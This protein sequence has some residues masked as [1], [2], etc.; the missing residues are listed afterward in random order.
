MSSHSSSSLGALSHRGAGLASSAARRGGLVVAPPPSLRPSAPLPSF[1]ACEGVEVPLPTGLLLGWNAAMA[2]FH[3]VLAGTTLA[4]G[5]VGLAVPVY[6]TGL[7][8][9]E[10]G[11]G[12]AW[13][14]I[15]V[16]V[17][18]GGLPLTVLAALFFLLSSAFHLL[19]CTLLRR[20]YLRELARCRTPTR[21]VEYTLSAPVMMLI[22]AYSLGVRE[23]NVLLAVA[24][25]TASTMPFGYWV[26]REGRPASLEEWSRPLRE[27]LLPWLLGHIPQLAAWA[28]ILLQFFDSGF[29]PV[30][31]APWW[32]HLILW[33]EL[34]LFLS[35]GVASV[36][37]QAGPP[38]LF[39]RGELLFQVLSLVSKGLLG[40]VLLANVLMRS[41][42]DDVFARGDGEA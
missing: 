35:F 3:A 19:N 14:L 33:A 12:Q 8:F 40:V 32:V 29:D 13:D 1:A 15:P 11:S 16:H 7:D 41:R 2:A 36:L 42:F 5:K 38:R 28:I 22:I 31:R 39:Y 25:L 6:R 21:W 27:R 10:Y 17:R 30:D 18:A 34:L 4:V 24:A 37:S 9:V 23:R 20:F 26:E